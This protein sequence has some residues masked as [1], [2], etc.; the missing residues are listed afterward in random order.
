MPEF[1]LRLTDEELSD[2]R[3]GVLGPEPERWVEVA[4]FEM[5][6]AYQAGQSALCGWIYGRITD[7]A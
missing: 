4:G 2:L 6:E 1:V 3:C 5:L 7:R